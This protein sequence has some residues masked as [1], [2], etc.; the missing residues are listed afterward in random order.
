MDCDDDFFDTAVPVDLPAG[1]TE[2]SES[3]SGIPTGVI[4]S[5]SEEAVPTGWEL[6][7]ITPP[8]AEIREAEPAV[9]TVLNRLSPAVGPEGE[10]PGGDGPAARS[11]R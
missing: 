6:V 10:G 7:S 4:C 5:V 1:D 2:I 11:W 8:Q 9:V 3:Y